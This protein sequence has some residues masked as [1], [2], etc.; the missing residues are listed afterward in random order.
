MGS[1]DHGQTRIFP[2][3][4]IVI[5]SITCLQRCLAFGQESAYLEGVD[6]AVTMDSMEDDGSGH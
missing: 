1:P 2:P 6:R 4:L 5:Y 3:E